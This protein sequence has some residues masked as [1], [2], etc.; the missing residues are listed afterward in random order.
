MATN[1]PSLLIVQ[2]MWTNNRL[3]EKPYLIDLSP[4]FKIQHCLNA[5]KR[6]AGR[7]LKDVPLD[8]ISFWKIWDTKPVRHVT[9]GVKLRSDGK[10]S[11]QDAK[12]SMR[13]YIHSLDFSEHSKNVQRLDDYDS[14]ADHFELS[15]LDGTHLHA[16]IRI[17][18]QGVC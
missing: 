2:C 1:T 14:V 12:T 13:D 3:F 5:V 16:I 8:D 9:G 11:D 6:S 18:P 15:T 17:R 10:P 4:G 7:L